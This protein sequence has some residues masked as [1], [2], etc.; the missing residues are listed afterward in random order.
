[1]LN[2]HRIDSRLPFHCQFVE[3][4]I[5]FL[6]VEH[7]AI[8]GEH[9]RDDPHQ[10]PHLEHD[11][12]AF[13]IGVSTLVEVVHAQIDITHRVVGN[14]QT[15]LVVTLFGVSIHGLHLAQRL[16]LAI[17]IIYIGINEIGPRL[18][19]AVPVLYLTQRL[20]ILRSVLKDRIYLT[21]IEVG[22][23]TTCQQKSQL[24]EVILLLGLC[25]FIYII[26]SIQLE[27]HQDASP[28]TNDDGQYCS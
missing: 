23:I 5:A 27:R 11:V 2:N 6:F 16:V 15:V 21:V 14:G 24:F 17:R 13:L 4:L 18:V 3:L 12:K 19:V 1:M 20:H 7:V 9:F 28:E 10:R 8:I 26:H 22:T 25:Y